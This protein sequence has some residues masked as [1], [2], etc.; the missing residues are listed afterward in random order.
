MQPIVQQLKTL[1]DEVKEDFHPQD[2]KLDAKIET[3]ISL[4]KEKL[5][6]EKEI[7]KERMYLEREKLNF[8]RQKAGLA[9][10][11]SASD[12]FLNSGF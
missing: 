7:Q 4:Q 12:D 1:F 5:A 9:P 6:F 8:K 10:L 11:P 2:S 3:L